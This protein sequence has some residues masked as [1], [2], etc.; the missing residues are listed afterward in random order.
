MTHWILQVSAG[1]GPVEVRAFVGALAPALAALCADRGL[2]VEG[3]IW[4]GP[5]DAP[6]SARIALTGDAPERLADLL[7]SHALVAASARRGRRARKRWFAGVSLHPRATAAAPLDPSEVELRA[8]R[9]GGPGGQHVNTTA[10]AVRARHLPTGIAV[11]ADARRSREA[12][13]KLAL[14]L[15]AERLTAREVTARAATVEAQRAAHYRVERGAPVR[16]W[17]PA[18][19]GIR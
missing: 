15:L 9:A 6:R 7:G 4:S 3:V 12:N 5:E 13:R 17:W 11:R 8:C 18:R 10:T 14:A 1:Q 16:I 2:A 19:G